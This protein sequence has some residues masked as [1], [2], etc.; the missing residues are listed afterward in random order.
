MP[1]VWGD[2]LSCK[3]CENLSGEF[4][5]ASDGLFQVFSRRYRRGDGEVVRPVIRYIASA[6]VFGCEV[7]VD[8]HFV[9][10]YCPMCGEKL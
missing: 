4:M 6:D 2:T 1:L 3:Y 10:Q 8:D 9:I 7:E 5:P